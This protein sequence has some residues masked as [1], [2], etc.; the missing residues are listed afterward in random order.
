MARHTGLG[1]LE[2][3]VMEFLWANESASAE[4]VRQAVG[5]QLTDSTVRTVLR[6]LEKKEYVRHEV[7]DRQFIYSSLREPRKVAAEAVR[8]ILKRF[9]R[10]SLEE[11]L[12][13]MVDHRIVDEAELQRLAMKVAKARR[14]E[15]RQKD[16][17]K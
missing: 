9:C 2:Q 15:A 16:R 17:K 4:E 1:E 10:G 14:A 3:Q 5:R 11:L 12:T 6:R 7:R 8:A 13:G